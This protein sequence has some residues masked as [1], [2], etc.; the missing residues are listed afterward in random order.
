M[1][2]ILQDLVAGILFLPHIIDL[3]EPL[4]FFRQTKICKV[5]CEL[6]R[7]KICSF[8][9]T[10]CQFLLLC[11][12]WR[13]SFL[14]C[15]C[16]IL[17]IFLGLILFRFLLLVAVFFCDAKRAFFAASAFFCRSSASRLR[18]ASI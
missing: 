4:F 11:Q 1:H 13:R 5:L 3:R 14:F 18:S 7:E 15:W 2:I 8:Q 10:T 17:L 12:F 6:S 16:L 9:F